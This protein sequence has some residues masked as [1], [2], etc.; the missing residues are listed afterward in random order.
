MKKN[1]KAHRYPPVACGINQD[2]RM[3]RFLWDKQ[4]AV[5]GGD[6]PAREVLPPNS[7]AGFFY[8]E[9]LL[10]GWGCPIGELL[11]LEALARECAVHHKWSFFVVS[12]P[13]NVPG[14][15][16]VRRIWLLFYSAQG[17]KH[18]RQSDR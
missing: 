11:W 5:V 17:L 15:L 2:I 6:A 13:L 14:V 1:E 3:L 12:V 16:L 9:V 8:H 18:L 10:A 4:V 7:E